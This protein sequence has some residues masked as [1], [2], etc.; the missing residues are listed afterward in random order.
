MK[1]PITLFLCLWGLNLVAQTDYSGIWSGDF[2]DQPCS[3]QVTKVG[4]ATYKLTWLFTTP[5]A[6]LFFQDNVTIDGAG[7]I[8]RFEPNRL[9]HGKKLLMENLKIEPN[10]NVCVEISLGEPQGKQ[11]G[12]VLG[13]FYDYTSANITLA[14][15]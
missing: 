9:S 12:T 2:N 7:K 8:Q 3:L 1:K 4:D 15:K 6:E 10:G 5:T 13:V 11:R 14:Q